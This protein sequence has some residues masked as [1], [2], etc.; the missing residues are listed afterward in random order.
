MRAG[1]VR[2]AAAAVLVAASLVSGCAT[3]PTDPAALEA[4]NEANDPFEP[5]NRAVFR[6][7]QF[8]DNNAI[9]PAAIFY[10]N[11]VPEGLRDGVRNMGRTINAPVTFANDVL[12]LEFRRAGETLARFII[13]VVTGL[14]VTDLAT[15]LGIEYHKEDFGQTLAKYGVPEGPFLMLP[16]LGPSNIRDAAGL[17]ADS[18]G[19]PM[20]VAARNINVGNDA[21]YGLMGGSALAGFDLRA[22]LID[23]TDDLQRTSLDYYAALRSLYRQDRDKEIRNG[24]PAPLTAE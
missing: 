11:N 16:I 24:R 5:A 1:F 3:R 6:F 13:N 15:E 9:R 2:C 17:A 10:R 7:N 19:D 14:G 4:Y 22:R 18:V 23:V 21:V 20:F 12:Q 8:V